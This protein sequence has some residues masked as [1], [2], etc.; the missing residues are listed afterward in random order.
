MT[1]SLLYN[2]PL[3][4]VDAYRGRHL[5]VR[6]R[7]PDLIGA[8]LSTKDRDDLAY[9]QILGLSAPVDGL[10]RWECGTPLDL[11][12]EKPTEE[13]PL[14]Y[15]Y[16]P[17]LSDRPVRVSVPFAPGFGKVVRLAI[18]L[19]FA[20]K[21][22]GSQPA[23]SL[24]EELLGVASDYLYRPSVS[25]PVEFVHSLFLAF[26]SPGASE[27]LGRAGGRSAPDPLRNRP[28]RRDRRQAIH[29]HGAAIRFQR[30]CQ[31]ADCR[32]DHGRGGM[33]RMRIRR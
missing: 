17:L 20:V 12:V 2:V 8:A 16:S 7:D 26:F 29:R 11:V 15:K 22:E 3:A 32:V 4:L 25:V 6:S 5:V 13:L 21:L 23:H 10:L 31:R 19:D 18:S 14:L 27:P 33:P 30:I 1:D 28:E 9:V 24:A